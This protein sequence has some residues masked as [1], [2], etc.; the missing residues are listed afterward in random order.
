M[1][2]LLEYCKRIRK[3]VL[4]LLVCTCILAAVLF[5]YELPMEALVYGTLLC[6][7]A[8]GIFFCFGYRSY[9]KKKENLQEVRRT[10][11]VNL[12]R[13]P[14]PADEI[15]KS[16]QEMLREMNRLRMTAES[17][18]QRFYGELTDYY[19]M[20]VHQIK[21]PI[22]ALR[23]I[24]QEHAQDNRLALA[25]LFKTEQYV[26]MV[27]GYLR[28][29]DMS[30]DMRF[31][32]CSLDKIIREQVHKYAGVF[33]T[34]KLALEYEGTE[35]RVLTDP[36][37]LGFVIGQV[38]SNALKYTKKGKIHIYLS[39]SRPHTLVIE[40]TGIGVRPEDLPRVFEKGFTGYNGR[41]ESSSTGIGLYLSGKI[42]KKL[43][44]GI[45]M[46]SVPGKGTRVYL[47]L[48]RGELE[49]FS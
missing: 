27:L 16:Y 35:E 1:K 26:E 5:L 38:L 18:K 20:W 40:D 37:W 39:E 6:S 10:L 19:T 29:E 28:T 32:E 46:E 23:L 34:K 48:K 7:L 21:T 42:M 45:S 47:E 17:D 22:A 12:D 41:K 31:Q 24:L 44:H 36:K 2:S 3:T 9:R 11:P 49:L 4:L 14:V 15:E 33:I 43:Q 25:E 8:E 13:M 30:S